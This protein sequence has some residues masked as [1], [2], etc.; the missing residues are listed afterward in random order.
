MVKV[1]DR[2]AARIAEAYPCTTEW[3]LMQDLRLSRRTIDQAVARLIKAG[4]IQRGWDDVALEIT[5]DERKSRAIDD[6]IQALLSGY[7]K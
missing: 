3:F 5:D 7:S 1:D 4:R 6:G 2:I